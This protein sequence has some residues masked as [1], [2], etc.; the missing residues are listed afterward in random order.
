MSGVHIE[1]D[2]QCRGYTILPGCCEGVRQSK[3]VTFRAC[4]DWAAWVLVGSTRQPRFCPYCATPLP[5]MERD[6]DPIT[7]LA[8]FGDSD[9]HCGT[10]GELCHR[11]DCWPA[12][13]G[14]QAVGEG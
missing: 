13:A 7:P 6:P 5:A 3:I 2:Y 10:C 12:E 9:N 4:D 11:C 8:S 14:W 1:V